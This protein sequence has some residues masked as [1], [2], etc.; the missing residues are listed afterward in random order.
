MSSERDFFQQQA[1]SLKN[2]SS[3]YQYLRRSAPHMESDNLL[4]AEYVLLVSAFDNYLHNIVRRIIREKFF[5]SKTL[6][7]NLSL[8]IN[9]IQSICTEED[10]LTREQLLDGALRRILKLS[11]FQG[12][13]SV[14]F[15]LK[16]I[17]IS[18]I[19]TVASQ[20]FGMSAE[21][22]KKQL[23]LLV[24]RRNQIAHES[25]VDYFAGEARE[26]DQKT[27]DTC[28]DF[29]ETLIEVI[30]AEIDKLQ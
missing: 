6:T 1:C 25:D 11:S 15:A 2:L 8:S 20:K 27:V 30:D 29:L 24:D 14:E 5:S 18:K 9:E 4:R 28:R 26:I 22:V 7:E 12:P 21:K 3:M 17:D 13:K 23:S 10:R 16:L 19:W